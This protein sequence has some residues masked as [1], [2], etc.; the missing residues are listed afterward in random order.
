MIT[1]KPMRSRYNRDM[2]IL[3]AQQ[4]FC[5]L[6]WP[7]KFSCGIILSCSVHRLFSSPSSL[8]P[9]QTLEFTSDDIQPTMFIPYSSSEIT[10]SM[11][12][13]P[14]CPAG[15]PLQLN[16]SPSPEL[17]DKEV[18]D[19][20]EVS[21]F[22]CTDE[23]IN[24]F[25][26]RD[27]TRGRNLGGNGRV[28]NPAISKISTPS[29][30]TNSTSSQ[31]SFNVT[32]SES[33]YFNP[34][35]T[36]NHGSVPVNSWLYG[37]Q[38]FIPSAEFTDLLPYIP[39]LNLAEAHGIMNLNPTFPTDDYSTITQQHE[40]VT[41]VD[42]AIL[43]AHV[44]TNTDV[45][46]IPDSEAQAQAQMAAPV[47]K[48]FK[49]PHCQFFSARKH[50]LKTHVETHN[51]EASRRFSCTTCDRRFSRKHDLHR[52]R[53]TIHG[54]RMSS[55]SSTSSVFRRRLDLRLDLPQYRT[56]GSDTTTVSGDERLTSSLH[57]PG[58]FSDTGLEDLTVCWEDATWLQPDL[59][60]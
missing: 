35:E 7:R 53:E 29:A 49:C 52:H 44:I 50:N 46:V 12:E 34:S 9:L 5:R 36:E 13:D 19:D 26:H 45:H 54:S 23:Q 3:I 56:S 57:P 25:F 47:K 42:P 10:D 33:D 40:T 31:Y 48:P 15:P 20:N 59:Q 21:K 51:K 22:H 37:T 16:D 41:C 14:C 1:M 39:P 17:F 8:F 24:T 60:A 28:P 55:S 11:R 43:S 58:S 2:R 6:K 38:A 27:G 32:S 30:S 18:D 4:Q